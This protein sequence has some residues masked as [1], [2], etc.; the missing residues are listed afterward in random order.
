[1][2][3]FAVIETTATSEVLAAM[4]DVYAMPL[5]VRKPMLAVIEPT[6][7]SNVLAV[8]VELL[9]MPL[10]HRVHHQTCLLDTET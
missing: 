6:A 2:P 3:T 7:T 5:I 1:M 4:V 9:A 10:N 8:N